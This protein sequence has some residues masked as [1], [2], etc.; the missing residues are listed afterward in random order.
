MLANF[1]I[2]F[3]PRLQKDALSSELTFKLLFL[4]PRKVQVEVYYETMCPDARQFIRKQLIPVWDEL[5]SIMDI[6]WKPYGK[7]QVSSI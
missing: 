5:H 6:Q 3:H 1:L 4:Q 2:L 7:A